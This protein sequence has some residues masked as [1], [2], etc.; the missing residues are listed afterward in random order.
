MRSQVFR[1]V[2]I[3]GVVWLF[4]TPTAFGA[5]P[6]GNPEDTVRLLII[7]MTVLAPHR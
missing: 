2:L 5:V 7:V 1:R 3:I 6:G 4:A